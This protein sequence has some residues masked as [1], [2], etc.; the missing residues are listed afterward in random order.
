LKRIQVVKGANTS[1]GSSTPA[2]IK[3][4]FCDSVNRTT[5]PVYKYESEFRVGK[6]N[7]YYSMHLDFYKL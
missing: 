2:E 5:E 1:K 3:T 7:I 6:D 4:G